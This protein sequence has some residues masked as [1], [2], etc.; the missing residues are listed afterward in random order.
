MKVEL[1]VDAKAALGE[2]PHWDGPSGL[3]YW[4][5]ISGSTLHCY[6]R[7][8]SKEDR[9][10]FDQ[11]V[12]AVVPAKDGSLILT[13]Q[14]GIYRYE[15]S[16]GM[17]RQLVPVEPELTRNRLNDAK[18]DSYGRLWA[19]TMSMDGQPE[20]GGLYMLSSEDCVIQKTLGGIGCSNGLAW[21][22]RRGFMYYIDTPTRRVDC[23]DYTAK[24]GQITN[25]RT[26]ISFSQDAGYP[27]GMTIDEEGMLWIAHWGGGCISRWNPA[28]GQQLEEIVIPASLVTSCAFGGPALDELY[29]TTARVGMSAASLDQ[30]PSAGGLFMIKPGVKGLPANTFG[31]E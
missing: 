30:Y 29:V 27:D 3:L 23:F 21:D 7:S 28:T 31:R 13:M 8:L 20:A 19:G 10:E 4:V 14:D 12:S 15:R 6:N 18:C 5:D 22:E 26:V 16:E 25:R 24:S 17:L 9:Y 1:V 11:M 2:G